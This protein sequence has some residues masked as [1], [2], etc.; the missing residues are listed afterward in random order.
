[1]L[2]AVLLVVAAA[3]AS[4]FAPAAVLPRAAQSECPSLPTVF[5]CS[6][7]ISR[8]AFTQSTVMRCDMTKAPA[9]AAS[10]ELAERSGDLA[11]VRHWMHIGKTVRDIFLATDIVWQAGGAGASRFWRRGGVK[12]RRS[13]CHVDPGKPAWT[14][15]VVPSA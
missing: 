9:G 12:T 13:G 5:C 3:S 7:G 6:V 4:A 1:M 2:R 8:A 11:D 14:G 10:M 15:R